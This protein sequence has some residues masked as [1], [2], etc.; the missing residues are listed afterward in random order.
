VLTNERNKNDQSSEKTK[1]C[2][3]EHKKLKEELKMYENIK[4]DSQKIKELSAATVKAMK[5]SMA[6]MK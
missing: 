4:N 6:T 2:S 3:K 5:E 1:T